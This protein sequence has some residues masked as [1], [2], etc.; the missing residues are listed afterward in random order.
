MFTQ[1]LSS[2]KN[3]G[4]TMVELPIGIIISI[5]IMFLPM[6]SLATLSLRL[7]LLNV[8]VQSAVQSAAKTVTY[9]QDT[10]AGL[11]AKNIAQ[12]KFATQVAATNGLS[13]STLDVHML[14]VNRQSAQVVRQSSKL[15]T[16]AD[17]F[18]FVYEIEA[19]GF[20]QVQPLIA[21]NRQFFGDLPGFTVPL[22]LKCTARQLVENPQGLDK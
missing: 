17:T 19:T 20:S 14:I 15:Q 22:T 11:S 3:S 18:H 8:A 7:T 9:E 21:G 10:P 12:Q 16:P 1:S 13:G 2:R 5:A 4:S 6:L